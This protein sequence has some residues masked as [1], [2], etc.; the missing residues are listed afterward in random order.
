MAVASAAEAPSESIIVLAPR[1]AL[2]ADASLLLGARAGYRAERG[3]AAF[4]E[5]RNLTD[6]TYAATTGI[7][8]PAAPA[9][10]QALFHPG[11]GLSVA[12]G[13]EWRY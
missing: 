6:A 11:D 8:N 3:F 10:G 5:R 9:A 7:A 1:E 13:A 4:A 12:A 2:T